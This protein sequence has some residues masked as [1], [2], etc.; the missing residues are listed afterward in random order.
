MRD[1]SQIQ[2]MDMEGILEK[3]L[4]KLENCW[5]ERGSLAVDH[6]HV[7]WKCQKITVLGNGM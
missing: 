6:S 7:F 5:R 4:E 2:F 1:P 3:L